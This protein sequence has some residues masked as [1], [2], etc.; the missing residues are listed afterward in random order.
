MKSWEEILETIKIWSLILLFLSHFIRCSYY[1]SWDDKRMYVEYM[2]DC[3]SMQIKNAEI[4][5]ELA[6]SN[7]FG[8]MYRE[9]F[10]RSP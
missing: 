4:V 2:A 7:K 8:K 10:G 6:C 5:S 1:L 9:V 3:K